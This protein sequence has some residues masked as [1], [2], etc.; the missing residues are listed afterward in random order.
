VTPVTRRNILAKWLSLV[1][2]TAR[3]IDLID[4]VESVSR[5]GR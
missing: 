4:A 2:P 1:N 3:A 5:A